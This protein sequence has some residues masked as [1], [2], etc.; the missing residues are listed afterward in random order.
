MPQ[1]PVEIEAEETPNPRAL[2][3]TV[4]GASFG[5]KPRS[6]ASADQAEGHPLAAALFELPG[7]AN[8]MLVSDFVT[9][10]VKPGVKWK[11]LRPRV[12][13]AIRRTAGTS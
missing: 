2:K 7:V 6:F 9:V 8:V 5:G 1:H 11:A 10:N 12:E 4:H 13:G 3:F